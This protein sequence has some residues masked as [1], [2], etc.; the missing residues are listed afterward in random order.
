[1]HMQL[2]AEHA[3]TC[4]AERCVPAEAGRSR[5]AETRRIAKQGWHAVARSLEAQGERLLAEG[6]DR[7]V[8]AMRPPRTDRELMIEQLLDRAKSRERAVELTR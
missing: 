4:R 5:L 2:L 6:V 1:M 7:F 3:M 8:R